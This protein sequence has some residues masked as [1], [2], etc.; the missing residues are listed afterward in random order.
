MEGLSKKEKRLMDM[1]NSVVIMG[2]EEECIRGLNGSRKIQLEK[3]KNEK[4]QEIQRR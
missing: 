3:E 2:R 4:E 1:D